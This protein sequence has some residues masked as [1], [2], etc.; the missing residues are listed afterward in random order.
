MDAVAIRAALE[1]LR[2]ANPAPTIFGAGLHGFVLNPPLSERDV[3]SFEATHRISLPSDYR[4]F[5][6]EVGNGGA[7]PHYGLYPLG[8]CHYLR[9]LVDWTEQPGLVGVPSHPFP[10]RWGWNKLDERPEEE[11]EG[12]DEKMTAWEERYFDA[13]FMDGTVP[14]SDLGCATGDYLV[15]TGHEA[16]HVWRDGRAD[17]SGIQPLRSVDRMRVTF[18]DWYSAWLAGAINKLEGRAEDPFGTI[19]VD[20]PDPPDTPGLFDGM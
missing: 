18:W 2:D 7:G 13:S 5:L 16:G 12:Y 8:T 20:G 15:V 14:L 1:R 3:A 9:S 19:Q 17:L 6:T 10:H 11:D 4:Q